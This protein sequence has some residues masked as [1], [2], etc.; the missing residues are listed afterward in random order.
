MIASPSDSSDTALLEL[1][2]VT[3]HESRHGRRLLDTISMCVHAGKGIALVG[4]SGAGK[5]TLTRT[6]VGIV[7]AAVGELRWR[8]QT[9]PWGDDRRWLPLRRR[10]S[11]CWQISD[12]A[13]D[14]RHALAHAIALAGQLAGRDRAEVRRDAETWCDTLAL[15]RALLDQRP[16]R[17][18][19]G[20]LQRMG[21]VRALATKP[22]LII[23]DEITDA[24]DADNRARVFAAL[25]SQR[26]H[27]VA[28]VLVTH[29]LAALRQLADEIVVV[30]AGRIVEAGPCEQVLRAPRHETTRAWIAAASA[31]A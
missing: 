7:D 18:S 27:G 2:D 4:P 25:Q 19:G 5:T 13:F 21:L 14:P 31:V 29:Q 6:L 26:R 30:D 12:Q 15:D 10:V 8:G 17:L 16:G 11:S 28:L 20:E 24:L 22:D 1:R 9:L 3:V 23:A